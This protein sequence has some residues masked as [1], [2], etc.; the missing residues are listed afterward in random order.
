MTE[1]THE[2]GIMIAFG[3]LDFRTPTYEDPQGRPLD[4]YFDIAVQQE[5]FDYGLREYSSLDVRQ[6]TED[7]FEKFF[8]PE[9]KFADSFNRTKHFMQCADMTKFVIQGSSFSPKYQR[10]YI[11]FRIQPWH[12]RNNTYDTECVTSA[13]FDNELKYKY[14]A[15]ANN[16]PKFR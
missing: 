6:C 7:D 15:L 14:I 4:Y 13:D 5:G 9:D 11:E 3:V 2:D 8:E 10:P 16:S 1:V 12:C